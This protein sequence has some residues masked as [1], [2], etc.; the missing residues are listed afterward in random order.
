MGDR[1]ARTV[2]VVGGGCSGVLLT[3]ELVRGGEHDVVL[4]EP[5][6]PGGGVAYG[7][8][9]PWHLL[10]SRAGA[11]SADPDDPGHFVRWAGTTPEAFRPRAEYGRYLRSVLD[12]ADHEHPGRLRIRRARVAAIGS[13]GSLALDDGGLVDA[14]HVVLATGGPA[15]VPQQI[16]HPGYV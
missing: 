15:A 1:M 5:G 13:D 9:R 8:A 10:N 2:A 12:E 3:R 7:H 6:R 14:D 11:M 4:I 16:D